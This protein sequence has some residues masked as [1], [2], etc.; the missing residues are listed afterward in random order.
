ME[1]NSE[2]QNTKEIKEKS[3]LASRLSKEVVEEFNL[4]TIEIIKEEGYE[5]DRFNSLRSMKVITSNFTPK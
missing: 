2:N 4:P 1:N 3:E 5:F